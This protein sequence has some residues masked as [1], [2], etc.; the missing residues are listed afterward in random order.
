MSRENVELVRR[1][2]ERFNRER[3]FDAI[4]DELYAPD[5]V[6]HSRA[7]EPDTGTYRGREA[8]RGMMSMWLE[9]FGD[10]RFEVDEYIDTGDEVVMPYWVCVS[11]PESTQEIRQPYTWRVK[12]SDGKVV[13]VHEHHTK[14]EALEAVRP[15]P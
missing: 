7:D 12:V 4:L 14:Q 10:L 8:I 9:M 15:R 11:A 5:A 2:V 13:E 6:Y 3:D 1:M